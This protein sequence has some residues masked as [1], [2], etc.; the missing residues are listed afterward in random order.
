IVSDPPR[1]DIP[2]RLRPGDGRFGCGPPKVRPG[3]LADLAATGRTFL[4]TSH[5]QTGV[6]SVVGE[7]RAGLRALFTAPDGYD[8]VLGTGGSTAFWDAA[9]F[10]L[11][12]R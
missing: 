4:G 10:G 7:I 8:V 11:V 3:A 2:A 5:R 12:E 1:I 6:R 9:S